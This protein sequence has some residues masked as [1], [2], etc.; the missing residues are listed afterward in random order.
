MSK[1]RRTCPFC[2]R[3]LPYP[4]KTVQVFQTVIRY[5]RCPPPCGQNFKTTQQAESEPI[6][7]SS[8]N[9]V[10]TSTSK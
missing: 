4:Y 2:G 10:S 7:T 8:G 5:F 6:N 9:S 1:P 3:K